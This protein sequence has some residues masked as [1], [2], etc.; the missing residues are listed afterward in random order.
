MTVRSYLVPCNYLVTSLYG[1]KILLARTFQPPSYLQH[2][3]RWTIIWS[4]NPTCGFISKGNRSSCCGSVE[5]NL[6]SLHEDA[7][8]NPGLAQWVKD[9]ALPW[10]VWYSL[11]MLCGSGIALASSYSSDAT[12]NLETSIC[13]GCGPKKTKNNQKKDKGNKIIIPIRNSC[14]HCSISHNSQEMEMT[15]VSV[16]RWVD[17]ENVDI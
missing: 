15:K 13:Q 3:R 12:P 10:T 9:A 14:V 4:I 16:H 2:Y 17:Q 5:T 6:T 11:Q 7:G 1:I 8:S